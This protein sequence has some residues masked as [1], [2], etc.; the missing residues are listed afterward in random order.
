MSTNRN[1]HEKLP[2]SDSSENKMF[3]GGIGSDK[4]DSLTGADESGKYRLALNARVY[5]PTERTVGGIAAIK[6]EVEYDKFVLSDNYHCIGSCVVLNKKVFFWAYKGAVE[7][8]NNPHY[9][10]IDDVIGVA[11]HKLRF[12]WKY[13]FDIDTN[14]ASLGGEIFCT[15]FF[16]V[17][18]YFEIKDIL[19]NLST[20]KYK[21]EFN[22]KLYECNI[23]SNND[24][25]VFQSIEKVGGS[26]GLKY[27]SYSYAMRFSFSGGAATMWS[28][29][30]N[31]IPVLYNYSDN[32]STD[33]PFPL[34]KN[35]GSSSSAIESQYGIK[36]KIRVN[37]YI[38]ADYVEIR[39]TSYNSESG[40][41]A[42]GSQAIVYRKKVDGY[43]DSYI[44][45]YVDSKI[46]QTTYEAIDRESSSEQR[47][48]IKR[49]RSIRYFDDRVILGGIEYEDNDPK[50]LYEF[51][52][53]VDGKTECFPVINDIGTKGYKLAQ[54]F[55]ERK[56]FMHNEKY[57]VYVVFRD[58]LGNKTTAIK[59]E[60]LPTEFVDNGNF[61]F[62]KQRKKVTN[63]NTIDN[64][65]GLF[66]CSD[67]D[68]NYE[69]THEIFDTRQCT[70]RPLQ[71]VDDYICIT[72]KRKHVI[73]TTTTPV[74]TWLSYNRLSPNRNSD[75]DTGGLKIN[76]NP[77]IKL[78]DSTITPPPYN[79]SSV[80]ETVSDYSPDGFKAR[81]NTMGLC[82]S[83]LS[84]YPSWA[85]VAEI[86]LSKPSRSVI[87]QGIMSYTYANAPDD[88]P[89]SRSLISKS[90]VSCFFPDIKAGI[91]DSS[92]I[93]DIKQNPSGYKIEFVSPLGY[94]P[95][96]FNKSVDKYADIL[97]NCTVQEEIFDGATIGRANKNCNVKTYKISGFSGTEIPYG[98]N[99]PP[100]VSSNYY[101]SFRK[102][103]NSNTKPL[104]SSGNLETNIVSFYDSG[105]DTSKPGYEL[106]NI[107]L[108]DEVFDDDPLAARD[109]T[110]PFYIV[111]IIKDETVNDNRILNYG[112][113]IK[114]E[115]LIGKW[116]NSNV[117]SGS[118][119]FEIVCERTEDVFS[120]LDSVLLSDCVFIDAVSSNQ[121]I[122]K[123]V[124]VTS[125]SASNIAIIDNEIATGSTSLFGF[126]IYGKYTYY[127]NYGN[128]YVDIVSSLIDEDSD[129]VV[130]YNKNSKIT[131]YGDCTSSLVSS[132]MLD[133]RIEKVGDE[134]RSM[135]NNDF[136]YNSFTINEKFA[137]VMS[138]MPGV[139]AGP[140]YE[141]DQMPND[142]FL[143]RQI[144]LLY[145]CIT[146]CHHIFAFGDY[147]PNVNYVD[148]P[149][150]WDDTKT[151]TENNIDERYDIARPKEDWLS[152]GLKYDFQVNLDY[153]VSQNTNIYI[154]DELLYTK[155]KNNFFPTRAIWSG[156]R[157]ISSYGSKLL[158][159]FNSL[160]IFDAPSN[161]G[162][163]KKLYSSINGPDYMLYAFC[164]DNIALLVTGRK[165]GT[166]ASGNQ[167][168]LQTITETDFIN[169]VIWVGEKESRALEYN[170]ELSFAE[171]GN[172]CFFTNT[173]SSYKFVGNKLYDIA[174]D[175]FAF[176]FIKKYASDRVY[177]KDKDYTS[178]DNSTIGDYFSDMTAVY[179]KMN[180]EYVLLFK[181]KEY[182]IQKD[183][184]TINSEIEIKYENGVLNQIVNITCSVSNS[185]MFLDK[186]K[187]REKDNFALYIKNKNLPFSLYDGNTLISL[188]DKGNYTVFFNT[189]DNTFSIVLS[190]DDSVYHNANCCVS[191][192]NRKETMCFN[193]VFDYRFSKMISYSN[194]LFGAKTSTDTAYV[195]KLNTG[196][197]LNG[198][199]ILMLVY[200]VFSPKRIGR[201]FTFKR[202]KLLSSD[203]PDEIQ[204]FNGIN[205][206]PLE[207]ENGK[208]NN[209]QMKNYHTFQNYIP[210]KKESEY[211]RQGNKLFF[212]IKKIISGNFSIFNIDFYTNPIK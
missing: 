5:A 40:I 64:S 171:N 72:Q 111:N 115:S 69:L 30:T 82:V 143:H 10:T 209:F 112:C 117:L 132:S 36:L 28:A 121:T 58:E 91:I 26:N 184:N 211:K 205:N 97:V 106:F 113:K 156:K 130:M 17:P 95:E 93:N 42:I 44:F 101:T 124:D 76:P 13:Q 24:F 92:I 135:L 110:Y 34:V 120:L 152:G 138:T 128:R 8:V 153:C 29:E 19:D 140:T 165:I 25:P 168:A 175:T 118:G 198:E 137:R 127:E 158:K 20:N 47:Q 193:G 114:L 71:T 63:Q 22:R 38:G 142:L 125:M 70:E 174:K 96:C 187:I 169:Q 155:V 199:N 185:S 154:Y 107:E 94:F 67:L 61:R 186:T 179:D 27:G 89:N 102:F 147:Y 33:C 204:F 54:N 195:N 73:A 136:I 85:K 200:S 53:D 9:I 46:N 83:G 50:G 197:K 4:I 163:I 62:P 148:R 201:S 81:W 59:I 151:V 173:I 45:D 103:G 88:D 177:K 6:G 122:K 129:I 80:P 166:D 43:K 182:N 48:K 192:S 162:D 3:F 109:I 74:G 150:T 116:R 134:F 208:V 194:Y 56:T 75:F 100:S 144:V 87:C 41:E 212:K 181:L 7:D 167:I 176:D 77:K 191:F 18:I 51:K 145:P 90:K 123:I 52:K 55:V 65:S 108:A 12:N 32:D 37:N 23:F 131:I 157:L 98:E 139:P 66:K 31:N 207:H 164:S 49:A 68:N 21:S 84:S 86:V 99:I 126:R 189:D 15:D 11:S 149:Y 39:R 78:K 133:T 190:D 161:F 14:N 203:K 160:N 104:F 146:R 180:E 178:L 141:T 183:D 188:V 35:I 202:F 119:T 105:S 159:Y 170:S 2:F 60:D 206:F 79:T 57:G 172:E 196:S 1:E 16:E 210:R